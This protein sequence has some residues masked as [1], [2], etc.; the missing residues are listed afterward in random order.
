MQWMTA[1]EQTI[2]CSQGSG[3]MPVSK[4]ALES[5]TLKE[6]F[7]KDPNF[8]VAIDLLQYGKARPMVPGYKELQEV[9]MTENSTGH[10]RAGDAGR[11]AAC[12]T[13]RINCCANGGRQAGRLGTDRNTKKHVPSEAPPTSLGGR[14]F[15][16]L[17]GSLAWMAAGRYG[18]RSTPSISPVQRACRPKREGR[19]A[20][21]FGHWQ[22]TWSMVKYTPVCHHTAVR[23]HP[24]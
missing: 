8:K 5:D 10:P 4:A 23:N 14:C 20:V 6:A 1:P 15:F 22:L 13:R 11:S 2:R 12:W 18:D 19:K 16:C 24:A 3:Y 21:S 9:I 17:G 7:V